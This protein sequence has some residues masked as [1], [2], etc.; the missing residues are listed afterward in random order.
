MAEAE[1]QN[2]QQSAQESQQRALDSQRR[3]RIRELEDEVERYRHASEDALQQLDW[4]IGYMHGSGKKGIARSLAKNR[5]YIR[6]HLCPPGAEGAAEPGDLGDGAGVEAVEHLPRD[7]AGFRRGS[8]VNGAE[9]LVALPGQVHLILWVAGVEA[10]A[11]LGLL[12]LGE[13][14]DAVAEQPANLVERVV[15]HCG[16]RQRQIRTSHRSS[17][18]RP[19]HG[20]SCSIRTRRPWPTAS[21]PQVGQAASS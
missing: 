13:V 1:I 4:C 6:T 15:A 14:F 12:A 18:T 3:A 19:K 11:E 2:S 16:S 10:A 20:A 21:T 8:V 7:L 17:V 9:L 5:A